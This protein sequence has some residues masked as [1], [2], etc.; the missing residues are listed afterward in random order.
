MKTSLYYH[1]RSQIRY[2]VFFVIMLNIIFLFKIFSI[3][4]FEY[5]KYTNI[6][7]KETVL[8][9]KERG[10]RGK[11]LDR[12]HIELAE[13]MEKFEFWVNT[14]DKFNR[15]TIIS[16]FAKN[17]DKNET[18]YSDLLNHK[19]HYVIIE[20]NIEEIDCRG[21][22]DSIANIQGLRY[23]SSIRRFYPYDNLTSNIIGFFNN[24][25]G[26]SSG[27]EYYFDEILS[28]EEIEVEHQI[29]DN[30]KIEHNDILIPSGKNIELTIDLELQT[31][32]VNEL[33]K[34]VK[35][36]GAESGNGIIVNPYNGEILAM[37]SIPDFNA[38]KYNEANDNAYKNR[39]ISENYEPGSTFKIVTL[40]AAIENSV[41]SLKD[42]VDCEN[43]IFRLKN[44]HFLHDHEPHGM[45]SIPEVF[46]FS[47]NIGMAKIANLLTNQQLYNK[48]REFGFGVS[49]G[50][51]LP[52]EESGVLRSPKDW[53]YQS[54]KSI[55]MGQEISCTSLQLAMAYSAI[56]NGGYL[57]Q[58]SIIKHIEDS[59]IAQAKVIRRIMNPLTS[60]IML[61]LLENVVSN[62]SGSNAYLDG[63]KIA[64]KTGTA[65]KFI[66]GEYSKSKY[67]S[68]FA[69]IFPANNPQYVCIISV[70]SPDKNKSKH[71]GNETAAPI[72][73]NIYKKIINLKSIKSET[74]TVNNNINIEGN[75]IQNE[76]VDLS[77]VPNFKGKTLK[78]AL[79]IGK[80][81][82]LIIK[83]VG[84]LG[85][86]VWQSAKAG[87]KTNN[88]EICELKVE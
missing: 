80:K 27:I 77:I 23:D 6:L 46:T 52:N 69:S 32:L 65:Q 57:L 1:Y 26:N 17:F 7:Y 3:Q 33:K 35:E 41:I 71:W 39:V 49:T 61:S 38:N 54:N 43:G 78:N 44:G 40:V 79:E 70:D 66:N 53:T 50:I 22:L 83:P 48:S 10:D 15:K 64:G 87:A 82:G 31:I 12:N 37:A 30:K 76:E 88:I 51:L 63:Y 55:A 68:S 18:Y 4:I 73:K 45:I 81:F 2:L 28:G 72:I 14:A 19:S 86:V 67:I 85:N 56:A 24:K 25:E 58:P 47:S 62:G 13:N 21:I 29:L 34:G 16:I 60:K 9:E 36:S 42:S 59:N 75:G 20:K 74:F 84:F 11:I 5:D 8:P